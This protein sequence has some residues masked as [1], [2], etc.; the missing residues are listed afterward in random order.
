MA[1]AL[2]G[3]TSPSLWGEKKDTL[4]LVEVFASDCRDKYV[5]KEQS[6]DE[7]QPSQSEVNEIVLASKDGRQTCMS[8]SRHALSHRLQRPL[9]PAAGH[10]EDKLHVPSTAIRPN[11]ESKGSRDA[12]RSCPYG[13]TPRA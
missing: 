2:V 4:G 8:M 11:R 5:C 10:N 6:R 7:C 9:L 1:A 13:R 3:L 12:V